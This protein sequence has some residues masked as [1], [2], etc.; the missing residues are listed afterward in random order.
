MHIADSAI[1]LRDPAR[2][3]FFGAQ[4][5]QHWR[6]SRRVKLEGSIDHDD[7]LRM[8]PGL[9]THVSQ[10]FCAPDKKAAADR[11]DLER[12]NCRGCL[13]RA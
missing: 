6:P 8:T 9:I 5:M 2:A 1:P 10:G 13:D 11:F 4:Q 3:P 7:G 12:P